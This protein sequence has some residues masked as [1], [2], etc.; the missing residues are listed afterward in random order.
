MEGSEL[1]LK[2]T[3]VFVVEVNSRTIVLRV[4][5]KNRRIDRGQIPSGLAFALADRWFDQQAASTKVFKG[6]YMAVTPRFEVAAVKKMWSDAASEGAELADL[7]KV[8]D[9]RESL[10][11]QTP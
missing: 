5:G 4:L 6:A 9:D 7:M 3:T 10:G 1:T 11:V 2:Q 8:L